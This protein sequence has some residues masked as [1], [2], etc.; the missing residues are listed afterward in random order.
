MALAAVFWGYSS[1]DDRRLNGDFGGGGVADEDENV[2]VVWFVLSL[3]PMQLVIALQQ[4]HLKVF[5]SLFADLAAGCVLSVF[6]AHDPWVLT[7]SLVGAIF[8]LRIAFMIERLL[9]YD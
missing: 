9:S 7:G 2:Q 5:S 8:S 4:F 3:S 1:V 6:G